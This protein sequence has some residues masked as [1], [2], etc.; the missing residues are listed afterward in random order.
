[1]TAMMRTPVVLV[2]LSISTVGMGC[3][4]TIIDSADREVYRVIQDRQRAALGSTTDVHLGAETGDIGPAP[5]MYDFVPRPVD[6]EL[7]EAFTTLPESPETADEPPGHPAEAGAATEAEIVAAEPKQ[8]DGGADSLPAGTRAGETDEAEEEEPTGEAPLT[9]RIF[10]DEQLPHVTVFGLSDAL[11]YAVDNAR[12]LIDAKE[13]LYLAALD[14]TLERHLWT[15]QFVADLSAEYANYGQVRDFDHAMSAVSQVGVSQRLPYGGEVT[16]QVINSLMRDLGRHITSGETGSAILSANIPLFRGAGRV[17]YE[18]RYQAEREL[19]Y[20]VRRYERFRRSFLVDIAAD[21]FDLQQAKAAITNAYK[22]YTNRQA[23]WERA[24]LYGETIKSRDIFDAAR[25]KSTLR[26]AE[27]SLVSAKENYETALDIFKIRVGMPV[28]ALLD[29]V[30]Q[31]ED[32]ESEA[33]ESLLPDVAEGEAVAVALRYRL[34][35]LTSADQVDDARRGVVIA[36]N[37][38]L[39]YLDLS[40]SVALDT[41]PNRKNSTSY[42]TERATWRG[43]VELSMDD[44]KAERNAYRASIITVRQTERRHEQFKDVVRS[45]VRRAIR[46]L[47]QQADL[48]WIQ[49]LNVAENDHRAEVARERFNRGKTTNQ[50]VVDAETALLAARNRL[51]SA[52]AAYRN[53]ILEFRRDTGTLRLS[54]DGKWIATSFE[55]VE[56]VGGADADLD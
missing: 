22:S 53:A 9:D 28:D 7:P 40:G 51:A 49:E 3:R 34:D 55:V 10:T 27:V 4:Q 2:L 24:D 5:G 54:D 31:F 19:I 44:R 17:A 38:I 45:D 25:A 42:N 37:S 6:S 35:L 29:V 16:A 14:L 8:P 33:L 15:P 11:A 26:D 20:A 41:D 56:P 21:Y 47:N 50:D 12:E 39:P 18:S 48:R 36:Q 43:M 23:D 46:R 52:V 13:D 32:E 30:D 1:M